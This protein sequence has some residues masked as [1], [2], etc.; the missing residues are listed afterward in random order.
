MDTIQN[1]ISVCTTALILF[2]L[3]FSGCG[4]GG[5]GMF[6][7]RAENWQPEPGGSIRATDLE[8]PIDLE[9]VLGLRGD[10]NFWVYGI[11]GD[12]GIG[13]YEVTNIDYSSIGSSTLASPIEFSGES[14]E[15]DLQSDFQVEVSTYRSKGALLG[16][17]PIMVKY[18]WGVDHLVLDTTLTGEFGGSP[19]TANQIID[20]WVPSF[21]L[22][23]RFSTPI[24]NNW[25]L[26]LDGEVAGLWVSYG[27]IDGTYEGLTL[28][29]GIRQGNGMLI[30]VGHRSLV[31]D[32][33]DDGT[34][35]SADVDIGGSYAFLEWAF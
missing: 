35:T 4:A 26:D 5:K 24:G 34:G 7:L 9:E 12:M 27:D 15:N 3:V 21:G 28:R 6:R 31:I 30:G 23:A 19:V 22:G 2:S 20:E 10:E 8:D 1:R 25:S 13:T 18:I 32:V 16:V 11:E 29:A 17:G 14:F 33:I